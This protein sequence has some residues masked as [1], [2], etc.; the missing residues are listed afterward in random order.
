MDRRSFIA[1]APLL[2]LAGRLL[3]ELEPDPPVDPNREAFVA[4]AE[5][6]IPARMDELTELM[7]EVFDGEIVESVADSEEVAKLFAGPELEP[8][9]GGRYFETALVL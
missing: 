2:P 3:L 8:V 9:E 4:W 6:E 1:V 7:R 5:K